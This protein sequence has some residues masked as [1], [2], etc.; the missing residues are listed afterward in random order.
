MLRKAASLTRLPGMMH[1]GTGLVCGTKI[2]DMVQAG[3]HFIIFLADWH[4]MINNKFGG[5][6]EKIEAA[7]EYFKHCFT[8]L[9]LTEDKV[10]YIWA[11]ELASKPNYWE[12]VIR[13]AKTTTAQ[14]VM[15]ALPIMGR[16]LKA[17]EVETASLFYPCMQAADIFEMSLDV[18]C[19][20]ID[21][22]KA[23]VL[24]REA[25]EKLRWGKPVALHTPMLMGLAGIQGSEK[26]SYDEDPKLSSVIAAK[27]SKSK[28]E[29]TILLHDSPELIEEKLRKAY[30]PPKIVEGNPVIEY[31]RL[32]AFP[33]NKTVTLNRDQ[34]YGGDM[35]FST[36]KELEEAYK[37]GKIHPQD[38]KSNMARI[39]A[40]ILKGVRE[41]FDKHPEPLEQMQK[42]EAR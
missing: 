5:D 17:Q 38:L 33:A 14:R 6:M 9:G 11:S 30:C 13:V 29:N 21:Q 20:G 8:A 7:G 18:A 16:D 31:Y 42:L 27:M 10:E 40:D 34:K 37:T 25:G 36:H 23:H 35:K 2:K 4:S 1:I 32:L 19:A 24:A 22:R 3:F 28:P 15:R 39:L 26:G 41:Y 12:R